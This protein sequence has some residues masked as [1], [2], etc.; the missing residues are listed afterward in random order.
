MVA[1]PDVKETCVCGK[2]IASKGMTGHLR[3][4]AHMLWA[5][6]AAAD[7]NNSVSSD[8]VVDDQFGQDEN[9]VTTESVV[10]PMTSDEV[11][12]EV[13]R[14]LADPALLAEVLEGAKPGPV[15]M[16]PD[17]ESILSRA[18]AGDDPIGLAKDL[19]QI[20]ASNDW[21]SPAHPQTQLDWLKQHNIPIRTIPRHYDPDAVRVYMNK[22]Y[23]DLKDA[24]WGTYW[25]IK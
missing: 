3:S 7:P 20:F 15:P 24:G 21:P 1:K 18:R 14:I 17:E 12:G 13:K 16:I 19:R 10:P 25:E 5:K 22:W 8:P 9:P 11:S 23:S 2:E 6:E 4:K